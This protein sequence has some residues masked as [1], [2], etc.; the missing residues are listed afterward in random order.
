MIEIYDC[1]ALFH[2]CCGM[3]RMAR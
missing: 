2:S 3:T 1:G